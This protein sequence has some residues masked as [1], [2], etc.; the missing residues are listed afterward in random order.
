MAASSQQKRAGS[1]S[2]CQVRP[3]LPIRCPVACSSVACCA[4]VLPACRYNMICWCD[5]EL[6]SKSEWASSFAEPIM[7][8]EH[9]SLNSWCLPP[10]NPQMQRSSSPS[11]HVC[12]GLCCHHRALSTHNMRWQRAT[13]SRDCRCYCTLLPLL[14]LPPPRTP[15]DSVAAALASS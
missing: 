10:M 7:K 9:A 6:I 4:S 8:G 12:R 5:P 14:L 3:V 15:F 11:Q 2:L 1:P 13:G